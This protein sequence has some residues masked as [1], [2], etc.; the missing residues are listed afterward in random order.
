MKVRWLKDGEALSV[1]HD[2][3]VKLLADGRRLELVNARV[4]DRGRYTCIG[5]NV[6]GKTTRDFT[7]SVLG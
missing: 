2:P 3:N 5:E 6:A 4:T 7:V 1:D